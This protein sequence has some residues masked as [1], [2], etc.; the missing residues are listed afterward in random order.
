[1][2]AQARNLIPV[3]AY[4]SS[5]EA[6]LMIRVL[7]PTLVFAVSYSRIV[8][9]K[10]ALSAYEI[11]ASLPIYVGRPDFAFRCYGWM[12]A[13]STKKSLFTSISAALTLK[14]SSGV[15][16][17]DQSMWKRRQGMIVVR[18]AVSIRQASLRSYI[19]APSTSK[20]ALWLLQ[21]WR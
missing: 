13:P 4:L 5:P 18:S 1:M 14:I 16:S 12:C 7:K 8:D 3:W 6:L 15:T 9:L 19:Q 11:A 17:N 2:K 10:L 21:H 20:Q